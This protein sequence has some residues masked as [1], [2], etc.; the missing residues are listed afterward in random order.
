MAQRNGN[1]HN[2][3]SSTFATFLLV[4]KEKIQILSFWYFLC[5]KKKAGKAID[6]KK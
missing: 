6:H 1:A 5:K 2:T 4:R 3:V